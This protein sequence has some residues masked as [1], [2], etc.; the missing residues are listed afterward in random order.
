MHRVASTNALCPVLIRRDDELAVLE[1]ALLAARRGES[2][3]VALAGEAGIGKTRLARELAG[4]ARELG[5]TVLAGACSDAELTLP[6]LPFLEAIGNYLDAAD[7]DRLSDELGP[8]VA[9]LAQIFPRLMSA[10]TPGAVTRSGPG[11]AAAVRGGRL[12]A[13]AAGP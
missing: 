9:D 7:T 13:G 10:S 11:Q 1:D 12:A 5:C 3:F 2:G 6:Y 8:G 4:E